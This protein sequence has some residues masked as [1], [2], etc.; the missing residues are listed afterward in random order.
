MAVEGEFVHGEKQRLT[1][2][3]AGRMVGGG[4]EPSADSDVRRRPL[5]AVNPGDECRRRDL[6]P[7]GVTPKGF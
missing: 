6:N 7:H 5:G 2:L 4:L 3:A 1:V